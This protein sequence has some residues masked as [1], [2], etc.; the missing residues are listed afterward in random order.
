MEYCRKRSEKRS[1]AI[2]E[3]VGL[4]WDVW[5]CLEAF[6]TKGCKVDRGCEKEKKTEA[7]RLYGV[8]LK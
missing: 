4:S 2:E 6:L 3:C 1:R 5:W 7:G 8:L